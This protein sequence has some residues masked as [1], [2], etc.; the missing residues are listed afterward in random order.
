LG[1]NARLLWDRAARDTALADKK[2]FTGAA[3]D[4][5]DD[6]VAMVDTL[7]G[8]YPDAA[9]YTPSAIL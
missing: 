5:V 2:A 4:Q 6:V 3:G 1:A 7:A 8:R 9:K